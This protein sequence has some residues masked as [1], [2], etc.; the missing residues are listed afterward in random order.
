ME[1]LTYLILTA[2]KCPISAEG[3]NVNTITVTFNYNLPAQSLML[4]F[5]SLLAIKTYK[6]FRLAHF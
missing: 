1:K 3:V 2:P 4:L 5:S 6:T